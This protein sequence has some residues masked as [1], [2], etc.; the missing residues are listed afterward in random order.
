MARPSAWPLLTDCRIKC[1]SYEILDN[2]AI[3]GYV[4]DGESSKGDD[5][6]QLMLPGTY[7][8]NGSKNGGDIATYGTEQMVME[9]VSRSF[10]CCYTQ[11]ILLYLFTTVQ[12]E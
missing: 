2:D 9:A 11:N 4:S 6:M 3:S 8:I 10:S 5:Y 1:T 12:Y 7:K